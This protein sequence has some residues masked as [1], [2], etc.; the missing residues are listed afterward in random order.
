M[1]DKIQRLKNL[2]DNKLMDVV[3]NYRQYGYDDHFRATA[4]SILNERGITSEYLELNGNF[5]NHTYDLAQSLSQSFAR[6]SKI[7]LILY[8]SVIF[9]SGF[10]FVFLN[11]VTAPEIFVLFLLNV[12]YLLFIFRA[13]LD[14]SRFYKTIGQNYEVEGALL[15]LFFGLSLYFFMYFRFRNQMR[16]RMTEIK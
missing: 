11:H 5:S 10:F 4:I 14:Q 16:E 15:Y 9:G 8:I 3:K 7:A 6:N 2:D 13:F 1:T 12:L